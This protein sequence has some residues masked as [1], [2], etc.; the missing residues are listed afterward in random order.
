MDGKEFVG[1]LWPGPVDGLWQATK[2]RPRVAIRRGFLRQADF[3]VLLV[4]TVL[5]LPLVGL[6]S[7]ID[8]VLMPQ[9]WLWSIV[10]TCLL[11]VFI[12]RVL[13]NPAFNCS[14][15]YLAVFPA[16]AGYLVCS[17]LSLLRAVNVGEGIADVVRTALCMSYLFML[18]TFLNE[19]KG[20]VKV[21][22]KMVVGSGV[23]LSLLC[24]YECYLSTSTHA[25]AGTMANRSLLASALLFMLPFCCCGIVVFRGLWVG[26]SSVSAAL[27]VASLVLLASRSVWLAF[28]LASS[29]GALVGV[30][31]HR[32]TAIGS[33][34]NILGYRGVRRVIPVILMGVLLVGCF[35]TRLGWTGSLLGRVQSMF[36]PSHPSNVERILL[37][38]KTLKL[39]KDHPFFGVGAGNWKIVL[40]SYGLD[41]LTPRSFKTDHFQRP[42][43]DYLWVL[44]ETGV[45]GFA[46]YVSLFGITIWY[47]LRVL[48]GPCSK[49]D[50][51]IA[52]CMLC[53]VAAYMTDSF[54]SFPKERIFHS[55]LL[56][57]MIGIV[58]SV[59]HRSFA[60]LR[61]VRRPVLVTF[62]T[63]LCCLGGLGVLVAHSRVRAEVHTKRAIEARGLQDWATVISEIDKGYSWFATLDPTSAPLKWYRGE[64]NFL[65]GNVSEAL[66]DFKKAYGAHPHHIYV[67][68]N[69]ATCYELQGNHE[70]AIEIYRR[71]LDIFPQFEDALINL[72]A[73]YYNSGQYEKAYATLSAC[74]PGGGNAR[75]EKYLE[76]ARKK[77]CQYGASD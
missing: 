38:K 18:A 64:A 35:S 75:L 73:T 10:L 50:R 60:R 1:V 28:L 52:V 48:T 37:W 5:I 4:T 53:G 41:N 8:P 66:E 57:L 59:Y 36:S 3:L 7:T 67:L 42:H 58:T 26:M 27:I 2:R 9:L 33:R 19:W 77:A 76:A 43:N 44:S 39:V 40:P 69:L 63:V 51:S 6:G 16:F 49:E 71:A 22:V 61:P 55:I 13:R 24:L 32:K 11:L 12:V 30:C 46:F 23:I 45:V 15:L 47:A 74:R 70:R 72:G 34:E 29:V 54:F 21:I 17:M 14:V 68:N 62:I 56:V 20:G 25:V 65:L 31:C